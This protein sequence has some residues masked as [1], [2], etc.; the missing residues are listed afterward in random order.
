LHRAPPFVWG[1]N[2][3]LTAYNKSQSVLRWGGAFYMIIKVFQVWQ[4]PVFGSNFAYI[5][6]FGWMPIIS[7]YLQVDFNLRI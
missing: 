3:D 5:T 1:L 6:T 7:I 2:G 4:P